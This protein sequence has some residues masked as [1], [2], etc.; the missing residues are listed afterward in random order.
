M[1]M[2]QITPHENRQMTQPAR[3]LWAWVTAI[4]LFFA[5][6]LSPALAPAARGEDL[7]MGEAMVEEGI[8]LQETEAPPADPEERP[9][10]AAAFY[11]GTVT[12]VRQ[13]FDLQGKT[14]TGLAAFTWQVRIPGARTVTL[15][16]GAGSLAGSEDRLV[17]T[18]ARDQ[19][20]AYTGAEMTHQ[21]VTME[22]EALSMTLYLTEGSTPTLTLA[23]VFSDNQ[24][25][26]SLTEK[27]VTTD[28]GIRMVLTQ[29]TGRPI[30]QAVYTLRDEGG[31]I[32]DEATSSALTYEKNDLPAGHYTLS[33]QVRDGVDTVTLGGD[34]LMA[35]P[36]ASRGGFGLS[37]INHVPDGQPGAYVQGAFAPVNPAQGNV[38][39]YVHKLMN[40]QFA[41][42][43]EVVSQSPVHEFQLPGEG[44]FFIHCVAYD[45]VEFAYAN[46][47]FFRASNPAP[48]SVSLAVSPLYYG[49]SQVTL[50]PTVLTGG[51]ITHLTFILLGTRFQH[52]QRW[53]FTG[54][55]GDIIL[56]AL[57]GAYAFALYASDGRTVATAYSNWFTVLPAPLT[58]TVTQMTLQP[59]VNR[60]VSFQI[61]TVIG[62]ALWTRVRVLNAAGAELFATNIQDNSYRYTPTA[63]GVYTLEVIGYDGIDFAG[64]WLTFTVT[65]PTYRALVMGMGYYTR[66]RYQ[67]PLPGTLNDADATA[68][69][70]DV[71]SPR[72][73]TIVKRKELTRAQ[74]QSA[75]SSTFSGA[76]ENDVS[77]IYYSGHGA[78]DGSLITVDNYYIRPMQFRQMLDQ[79]PGTKIILIDACYSG[80][81]VGKGGNPF[82]RAFVNA[83]RTT[84]KSLTSP[85]YYVI[86]SARS[87]QL[88]YEITANT[89]GGKKDIGVF[90][91]FLL[92]AI[93]YDNLQM[94]SIDKLANVNKDHMVTMMEA[95]NYVLRQAENMV[96]QTAQFYFTDPEYPLVDDV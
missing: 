68:I 86:T 66:P 64:N 59:S 96:G 79:I 37:S 17:V 42:V 19:G 12:D 81:L 85:E 45:G 21:Q 55:Q 28:G 91:H 5:T 24:P 77:L 33:A 11:M 82:A 46:S 22:G 35:G 25:G 69:A 10:E 89:N 26:L 36:S 67:N 30:Q 20:T 47:N 52:L 7:S 3:R 84:S 93:G 83:F 88:S 73:T 57:N 31:E 1:K 56:P 54:Q 48:L 74:M 13:V 72:Y 6:A 87:D 92:K 76:T 60:P 58:Q 71:L 51:P 78:F 90:T 27:T 32:V 9:R 34:T 41:P 49:G 23:G 29:H 61:D 80:R 63:E 40:E 50:K 18:D 38:Q 4:A 14:W 94:R 65:Q 95:Y 15:Q 53:D 43:T 16:F 39:F 2:P 70:L 62:H 8:D 75:I 44:V